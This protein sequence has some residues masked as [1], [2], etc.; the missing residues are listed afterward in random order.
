ML[1]ELRASDGALMVDCKEMLWM[2]GNWGSY[3]SQANERFY[4]DRS[5][6]TVDYQRR[7]NHPI[8]ASNI[9]LR[10]SA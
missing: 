5:M 3:R 9:G 8:L 7:A 1:C 10:M 4:M 2:D 6:E